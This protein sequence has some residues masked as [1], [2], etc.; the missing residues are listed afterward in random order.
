M[1]NSAE[2][3]PETPQ[4]E[5]ELLAAPIDTTTTPGPADSEPQFGGTLRVAVEAEGEGLNLAANNFAASVY[6]MAY[7]IFDPLAYRQAGQPGPDNVHNICGH[8]S[9]DGAEMWFNNSGRVMLHRVWL[10]EETDAGCGNG[11]GR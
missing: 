4:P 7:P 6:V 5:D 1:I 8:A 3:V 11:R 10:G 9:P 2:G